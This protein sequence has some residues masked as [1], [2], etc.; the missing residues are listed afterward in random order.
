MHEQHEDEVYYV[1]SGKGV[2]TVDDNAS[3]DDAG[4]RGADAAGQLA[5]AEAGRSATISSC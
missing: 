2:M 5:L 4:H 1:L 3:R